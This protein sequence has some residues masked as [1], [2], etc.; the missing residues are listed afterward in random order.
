MSIVGYSFKI[1]EYAGIWTKHAL[2]YRAQEKN[3]YKSKN[4]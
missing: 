1:Q 3:T 2:Q 4:K